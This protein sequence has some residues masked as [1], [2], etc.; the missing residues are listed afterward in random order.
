MTLEEKRKLIF[1]NKDPTIA[2]VTS[3]LDTYYNLLDPVTDKHGH[4]L[5]K[6]FDDKAA[7]QYAQD[8][9]TDCHKYEVLLSKL[10]KDEELTAVD[11]AH[12]GICYSFC[13]TR[14][15]QQIEAM[16]KAK[17]LLSDISEKISSSIY[18]GSDDAANKMQNMIQRYDSNS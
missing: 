3:V 8:M 11:I 4:L 2:A 6:K 9:Q 10:K 7:L 15:T 5:V 12:V 17:E 13:I 16:S 18:D 14:A 1:E